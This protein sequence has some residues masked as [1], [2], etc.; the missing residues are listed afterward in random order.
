M[1]S[2]LGL[3]EDAIRGYR[4]QPLKLMEV[5]GTHTYQIAHL[6]ISGLL[7]PGIQLVSGPGCPVC[8]TPAGYIDRAIE[9]SKEKGTTLISFG[10][11]IRVPGNGGSLA[12]AKAQGGS[13]RV[14]YSPM[15]A[16]AWAKAEPDRQF[17]VAAVGFETT[18]PLYALLIRALQKEQIKNVKLLMAVKRLVPGL[19]WLCENGPDIQGFI[20]PGH[21]SAVVGYGVYEGLCQTYRVPLAVAGFSYEHLVAALHDLLRQ[22]EKGTH[23]AHNLYPGVVAREGNERALALIDAC[24]EPVPSTW[25]GLGAIPRSGFGLKAAFSLYDAGDYSH[26][27][28]EKRGCQCAEVITGRKTPVE[29]GLFGKACSPLNP[30]G[31]CMVSAEGSCGIWYQNARTR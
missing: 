7:P 9:I 13:V 26:T 6:G 16:V 31:P 20:G 5:C 19:R 1:E 25:R 3:L 11:M 12:D 27:S 24:F 10:D 8:V 14:M 2:K 28:E 4:G 15:D 22:I 18:L 29:C 17:V 21:V 23:E 30:V